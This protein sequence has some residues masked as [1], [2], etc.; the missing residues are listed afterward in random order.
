MY[1][2]E[3]K[4]QVYFRHTKMNLAQRRIYFFL[5]LEVFKSLFITVS[6]RSY[7]FPKVSQ[8]NRPQNIFKKRQTRNTR[9][10]S[11]HDQRKT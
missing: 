2:F 3:E 11:V 8:Y 7:S 1:L 10:Q 4:Y 5:L 9:T 6:P